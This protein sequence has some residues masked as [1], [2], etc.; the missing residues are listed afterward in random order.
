MERY[1]SVAGVQAFADHE[2][3]GEADTDVI[4][5]CITQ[6]TEEINYYALERHSP[7]VLAASD[8]IVRW[9]TVLA[10]YFLCERRGNSPPD[11]LAGEFARIMEKLA[12]IPGKGLAGLA[13]RSDMRPSITNMTVDRRHPYSPV[14]VNQHASDQVP[15]MLPQ[16]DLQPRGPFT[17]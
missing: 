13:Q 12:R 11:S 2:Q 8:L 7:A 5:D 17:P 9:A 15:S 14:R 16:R 1:F 4:A 3:T 10:V 6:A